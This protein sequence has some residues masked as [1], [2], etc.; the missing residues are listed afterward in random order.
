MF[1]F[2]HLPQM[3]A[4]FPVLV[5][6]LQTLL[7]LL[8]AILISVAGMA[9]AIFKPG[10]F[11]KLIRFCWRQKLFF[12]ALACLVVA[13]QNVSRWQLFA[14]HSGETSTAGISTTWETSRG[15]SLRQGRGP[16]SEDAS[17]AET[18]WSNARDKTVL[19]SPAIAGPRVIFSTATE[20][21]PFSPEGRGA[22][23]C[24]DAHTGREM[25]RY[26]PNKYR[27]TFSSPVVS[28]QLVI[29]GEG[30]H[31]VEDARVTCLD[32]GSGKPLWEFRTQSHVESTP[33]IAEGCVY[34]GA[35]S[36]GFYCLWNEPDLKGKSRVR[37]HLPATDFPDC[38]S[39]PVVDDGV[40]YFGLGDGGS[41]VC[42][43]NAGTGELLW[44]LNT[45]YPVFAP[46]TVA[47]GKL[48]ISTGN[49]N[50]VQSASDLL[51]MKLQMLRDDGASESELADAHSRLKPVGEV[52]CI[53]LV[54]RAVEWKFATGDAILGAVAFR[55]SSQGLDD[56][57][58]F[59]SRDHHL[60]RV[61]SRGELLAKYDSQE[62][63]ISSPALGDRYVYTTTSSGR[64]ICHD[65]IS[66]KPVWDSSLGRG[67][68]FTSSPILA[69]G[70]LY[71]GT[72]E[73]GI[74]C[75]GRPGLPEPPR[76]TGDRRSSFQD[77][78]EVVVDRP[79]LWEYPTEGA[80]PFQVTAPLMP[81][82]DALYAAGSRHGHSELI[83]LHR[84]GTNVGSREVWTR[85]F[86]QPIVASP[87]GYGDRIC[88]LEGMANL[89][90]L[91]AATGDSFWNRSLG[92]INEAERPLTLQPPQSVRMTLSATHVFAWTGQGVLGCF[93]LATGQ[94]VWD[95]SQGPVTS[96]PI[97]SA[98]G[99]PAVDSDLLV[100]ITVSPTNDNRAPR[101][102]AILRTQD[103]LT[104][105]P[106]WHVE[107]A[108]LPAGH[109]MI[110]GAEIL[111]ARQDQR[112]DVYGLVDGR[113]IRILS[114][115]RSAHSTPAAEQRFTQIVASGRQLYTASDSGKIIC[116][117]AAEP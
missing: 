96:F 64:V 74:T 16:G 66:L 78:A 54:S 87:I 86:Q 36:D 92:S 104:G 47:N 84:E 46:P 20:I 21:G 49:G 12:G 42:A 76:W 17:I 101:N 43:V 113:L 61:S 25:W 29:C 107:M 116:W 26:A 37:W 23:V 32:L 31:Q 114:N 81:F 38:E 58:F 45:P 22:I 14:K 13:G 80:A 117:G 106:L 52:W 91:S 93:E 40:V 89:H 95:Q 108:S 65:R 44:K 111:V 72:A 67:A 11:V 100:S 41:A 18:I 99:S 50:Y 27:A 55:R 60:Y 5:G 110:E 56:E 112:V 59:T 51:E 115:Q 109:P 82:D 63:L 6:P 68:P 69:F 85:Q 88:V 9:L 77:D 105:T 28:G 53:D 34:F 39:S 48:F 83:K 7:A 57:L 35:G 24:V 98:W 10:G 15:G 33:A 73:S 1:N 2:I 103:A 3:L 75:L 62:P 8:P 4:V 19:S 90:C 102:T 30:L 79:R 94:P 97:G 71:V 70:H